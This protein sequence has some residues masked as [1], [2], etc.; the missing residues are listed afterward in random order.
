M[1]AWWSPAAAAAAAGVLLQGAAFGAAAFAGR[2]DLRTFAAL[3]AAPPAGDFRAGRRAVHR[4]NA[5][6]ACF[7]RWFPAA[8]AHMV[9]LALS[10]TAAHLLAWRATGDRTWAAAAGLGL[11]ILPWT[12]FAMMGEI[13]AISGDDGPEGE[14]LDSLAKA[15]ALE[16]AV[17]SFVRKHHVR[18]AASGLAFVLAVGAALAPREFAPSLAPGPAAASAAAAAGGEKPPGAARALLKAGLGFFTPPTAD[19]P[20]CEVM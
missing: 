2:V 15:K 10:A 19:K 18:T 6:R 7:R 11:S 3:A 20:A 16:A 5:L 1:S 8:K 14:G 12:R 9:P 17:A 4:Q 13:A